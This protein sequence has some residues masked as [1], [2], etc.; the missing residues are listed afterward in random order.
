MSL[1]GDLVSLVDRREPDP[2]PGEGEVE[3]DDDGYERAAWDV[4]AR[5]ADRP[6][7]VFAY[8]SLIWKPD[9][10]H[11]EHRI[12]RAYG[13]RRSF[14]LDITRWRGTPDQPGLMLAL[15][16]GGSCRGVAYRLPDGSDHAQMVRLLKREVSHQDNLTTVRWIDV[17]TPSGPVRALT[18]WAVPRSLAYY[19]DLPVGEQA[20]RLARAAGHV[21][22]CAE[23]LHNTVVK[24]GEL[25]I[26][27]AYLWQLQHLVAEEIKMLHSIDDNGVTS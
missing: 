27:D 2:G 9:F 3:L 16:A 15:E 13:W 24:L 25:G 6:L 10:E 7:W 23:Y 4:L 26:H 19:I 8:G 22:S 1:T 17:H 21:G 12:G 11:V 18:F 14:C 5:H 20:R